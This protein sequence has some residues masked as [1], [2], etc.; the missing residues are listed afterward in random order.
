MFRLEVT[1]RYLRDFERLAPETRKVL[2]KKAELL[3]QNPYREKRLTYP[4]KIVFRMR[5]SDRGADKRLIY[6]V[7]GDTISLLAIC[8]RKHGY[9]GLDAI[10]RGGA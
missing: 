2:L 7:K 4:H 10:L 3:L 5:F 1:A 9:D 6:V 8:D